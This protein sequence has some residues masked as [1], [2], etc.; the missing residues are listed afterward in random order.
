MNIPTRVQRSRKAGSKQPEGTR[1]C[2]RH[3]GYN[4]FAS[5]HNI[6]KTNKNWYVWADGE[7]IRFDSQIEAHTFSVARY[8]RDMVDWL[9]VDPEYFDKL[10]RPEVKHLSCF[11]PVDL[12]CHVDAIIEHLTKRAKELES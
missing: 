10:L 1:Y 3:N 6:E 8:K 5:Q 12:P 4:P 7:W 2:G 11:C 9:S